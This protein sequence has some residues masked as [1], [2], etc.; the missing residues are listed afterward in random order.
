MFQ[1]HL[2]TMLYWHAYVISIWSQTNL[3]I[4][5]DKGLSIGSMAPDSFQLHLTS[6]QKESSRYFPRTVYVETCSKHSCGIPTFVLRSYLAM[7]TAPWY[8]VFFTEISVSVNIYI[9][10][11]IKFRK[12]LRD[13]SGVCAMLKGSLQV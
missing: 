2:L 12:L 3:Q 5:I 4:A 7:F 9:H 8:Y 1:S 10:D 6:Q 11:F 13:N